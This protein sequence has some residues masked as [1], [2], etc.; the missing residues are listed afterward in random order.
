MPLTILM[1]AA[2][3]LKRHSF[4]MHSPQRENDIAPFKPAALQKIN[5]G[6]NPQKMIPLEMDDKKYDRGIL[7][8]Q[9]LQTV[10]QKVIP[11]K[12]QKF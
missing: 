8:Y 1:S 12:V 9:W 3:L 7:C 4:C 10:M 6:R 11:R 2:Q 5:C